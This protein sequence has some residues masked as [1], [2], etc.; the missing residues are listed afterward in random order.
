MLQMTCPAHAMGFQW[1]G[2]RVWAYAAALSLHA[3]CESVHLQHIIC[4]IVFWHATSHGSPIEW[5]P[6]TAQPS[7]I[8][9][10]DEDF[11][12]FPQI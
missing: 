6:I 8:A 7:V 4:T 11:S 5:P 9:T 1:K 12:R 2:L 10:H 3:L